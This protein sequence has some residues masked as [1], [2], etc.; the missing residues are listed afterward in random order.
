V[1][2]SDSVSIVL[3]FDFGMRRIGVAV[4][5]GLTQKATPLRLIAHK[6]TVPWQAIDALVAEWAPEALV[7]GHPGIEEGAGI[8]PIIDKFVQDL[9]VRYKLAV[10]TVDESLSSVAARAALAEDRRAGRRPKR[11][12]KG[13]V[14]RL[15]ACLIAEQWMRESQTNG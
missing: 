5:N 10:A 12:E 9:G 11:V 13:D 15:A 2:G 6:G 4:G 3:A 14:D 1:S 7:V 8:G